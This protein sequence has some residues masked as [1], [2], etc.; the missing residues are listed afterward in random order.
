MGRADTPPQCCRSSGGSPPRVP[1]PP[2]DQ[3]SWWQSLWQ[4]GRRNGPRKSELA[5][6]RTR[7]NLRRRAHPGRAPSAP[8]CP[9]RAG[10]AVSGRG[11][12]QRS[13]LPTWA[14][15]SGHPGR[16]P[17]RRL[18]VAGGD[19][20]D[21]RRRTWRRPHLGGRS[22]PLGS[23]HQ[24][25]LGRPSGQRRRGASKVLLGV[26]LVGGRSPT[27]AF[28]ST[29]R[30]SAARDRLAEPVGHS[31]PGPSRTPWGSWRRP[32]WPEGARKATAEPATVTR[33]HRR[34]P[35]GSVHA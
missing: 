33:S 31:S 19:P 16:L 32:G 7:R 12:G 17:A 35:G 6:R 8:R 5:G 10:P 15:S 14:P 20:L 1:E 11:W 27:P 13:N 28:A 4:C 25:G 24:L 29:C 30:R 26:E 22:G 34:L 2:I 21:G 18:R 3:E 23:G 9:G